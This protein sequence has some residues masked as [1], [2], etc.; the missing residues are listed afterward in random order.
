MSNFFPDPKPEKK[1]KEPYKGLK[2]TALKKKPFIKE[3]AEIY[4]TPDLIKELSFI[5]SEFVRLI[6]ANQ[7]GIVKC[8]T[9]PNEAHWTDMQCG[10]FVPRKHLSTTH[11]LL[12]LKVQ[13]PYC[14]E[15]LAG[16]L[17]V[18]AVRLDEKYGAGTAEY[19]KAVGRT[20][21]KRPAYEYEE[22]IQA[23]KILVESLKANLISA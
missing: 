4:G 21:L 23:Y 6:N 20:M 14:N 3:G 9:C 19:L 5:M 10:H 11:N 1:I 16:N 18:Y 8:F 2:R 12:N 7:H 15:G 22:L 13:C 17:A